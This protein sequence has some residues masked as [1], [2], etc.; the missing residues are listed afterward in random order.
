MNYCSNYYGG[1]GSGHGN[2]GC[3]YGCATVAV[4]IRAIVHAAMEDT[5]LLA[6]E[7]LDCSSI[8]GVIL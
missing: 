5:S 3:G 8:Q 4:D 2:L 7:N 1:L 6:S